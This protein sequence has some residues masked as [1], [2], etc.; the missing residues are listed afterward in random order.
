MLFDQPRA[1]KQKVEAIVFR[2][3][4]E[5]KRKDKAEEMELDPELTLKPDTSK[6]MRVTSE[7]RYYHDGKWEKECWSCC[8]NGD[9]TSEGCVAYKI[10]KSRWILSSYT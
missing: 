1:S 4:Q 3:M 10:D 7:R 9:K 5:S 6:T 2:Q 8:M